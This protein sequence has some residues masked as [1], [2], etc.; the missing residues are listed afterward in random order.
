MLGVDAGATV[1]PMLGRTAT[2]TPSITIGAESLEHVVR[3]H[4]GVL[5]GTFE[6]Y[7]E[8]VAAEAR[9]EATVV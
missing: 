9:D 2:G 7:R 5:D 6:Q 1:K 3:G 4:L 8:F